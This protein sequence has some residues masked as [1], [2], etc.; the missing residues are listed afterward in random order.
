MSS[1][2]QDIRILDPLEIPDWNELVA[3]TGQAT[4]FHSSNWARVLRDSYGYRP[5]YFTRLENGNIK[6][7][8]PCMEIKGFFNRPRGVAL[9]FSDFCEPICSTR[10][11]RGELWRT[12]VDHGNS[13]GWRTIELRGEGLC[14]GGSPS[15]SFVTHT[16]EVDPDQARQSGGFRDSTR[17]NVEKARKRGVTTDTSSTAG[18][19]EAFYGLHCRTRREHGL[20]PQPLEFFRKVQEKIVAPGLGFVALAFFGGKAVAGAVFFHFA[21]RAIFKYGASDKS[22]QELRANNLV[23]GE[24]IRELSGRGCRVLSFGRTESRSH[25]LRQFK[26]GWGA[27]ESALHYYTYDLR[28]K[29]HRTDTFNALSG[30]HTKVFRR[31]PMFLLR[32]AGKTLYR[33]LG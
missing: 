9:P 26:S 3:A 8:L 31:T 15:A 27:S 13:C 18:M 28:L 2:P 1:L 5:C 16:L 25:G 32:F 29:A 12:A 6:V 30:L 21:G 22:L 4:I 17:R 23:M 33:Y 10:E 7:L 14:T 20:P 11:E 19:M 24:A